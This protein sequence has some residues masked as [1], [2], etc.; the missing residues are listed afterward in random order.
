M[1]EILDKI[2]DRLFGEDATVSPGGWSCNSC[3][4]TA[5]D[6]VFGDR[7]AGGPTNGG[8]PPDDPD[9][10]FTSRK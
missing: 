3:T 2:E 9:C 4:A 7:G 5:S 6:D 10:V 1:F 8:C